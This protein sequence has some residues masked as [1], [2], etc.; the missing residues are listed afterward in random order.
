[1]EETRPRFELT[2]SEFL[3]LLLKHQAALR[4][5]ARSLVPDWNLVDEAVQEASVTMWQKRGQ[6]EGPDGFL[7]WARVVLRF[8]CLRQVEKLRAQRPL[9]SDEM[10]SH[11]ADRAESLQAEVTDAREKAFRD[12]LQKF[13]AAHRELLLAPHG[14]HTSVVDLAARSNKTANALYKLLGRLR[15]RLADC[16]RHTLPAEA[17]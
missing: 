15:E 11:L 1:M 6:L 8:K 13:S 5:Y 2:E 3:T 4:A 7:P 14:S 17:T 10:L 16:I 12:C 9:L